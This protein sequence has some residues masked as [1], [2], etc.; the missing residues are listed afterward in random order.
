MLF[1]IVSV[2]KTK[3]IYIIDMIK[4]IQFYVK[5]E[6]KLKINREAKELKIRIS[7]TST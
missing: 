3:K 7:L 6:N 2:A 4:L 5:L 1:F